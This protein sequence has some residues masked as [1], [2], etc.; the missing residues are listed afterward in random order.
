MAA[1]G[2]GRRFS[3]ASLF[4]FLPGGART[5]E[6]KEAAATETAGAAGEPAAQKRPCRAC[7][8]FKTWM[9]TQQ[10]RETSE[11][12]TQ[13][14][15][16]NKLP[17]DCPLDR[18]ELGRN[19]W[20]FLHTMAAY[21]PDCPTLDQQEEMAQFV[22]LFSKFFPCHECAEDIRRRS[23]SIPILRAEKGTWPS[24]IYS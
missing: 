13:V 19:S 24:S 6:S 9:K 14:A 23:I 10:A 16:E 11:N 18:E 20:A 22:H 21:Y 17:A 5:Q 3:P 2:E 7:V 4:S 12:K 15:L 8:D 1:P